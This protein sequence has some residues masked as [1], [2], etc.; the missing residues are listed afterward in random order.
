MNRFLWVAN[1]D[2]RRL[3]LAALCQFTLPHPPIVYYGTEVGLSQW[4]D[5]EY[6]DG[7]RRME[8]SRTPMP[9][10]DEQ[11][12]DRLAF[13]RRLIALRCANPAIWRGRRTPIARHRSG[14][15]VVRVDAGAEDGAVVVLNRGDQAAEMRLP[16]A[17]RHV[18]T[19][20]C[21]RA[22]SAH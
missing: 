3:K 14:L 8:E 13:Y 18:R 20:I 6:S 10:G 12:S 21:H 7:S 19:D 5:L 2:V 1:G 15:Y 17:V 22:D 4:H 11:D 9:W 16:D